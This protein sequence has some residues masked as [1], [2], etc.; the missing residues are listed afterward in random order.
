MIAVDINE[1]L[2]I[3]LIV[4]GWFVSGISR[5]IV[6]AAGMEKDDKYTIGTAIV[7]CMNIAFAVLVLIT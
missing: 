3:L 7:G 6:G 1:S 2:V 5:I 4:I